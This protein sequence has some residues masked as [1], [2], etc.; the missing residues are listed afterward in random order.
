MLEKPN[1]ADELI[2]SRLQEEYGI[3]IEGLNFHPSGDFNNAAYS[4]IADDETKYFLKLRK[5]FEE[6][7]VTVPLFLRSQGIENIIVPYQTKSKH[8]WA[9]FG[10]YEII[11]YPFIEGKNGFEIELS[12][13]HKRNL[14]M[15]L[16]AIHSTQV[17]SKLEKDIP[18]ETFSAQWRERVKSF[19]VQADKISF[20]D[21]V[22]AKLAK[23]INSRQNEIYHL[24][25]HAERLASELQ[26]KSLELVLC[27]SDIH[28]RNI[29]ITE[30]DN[31]YIVDWDNPIL[32]PKERDLMFIGG[33]I[34]NIWT[35]KRNEAV[36]YEGYGKTEL[37]LSALAYYRFERVIQDVADYGTQLLLSEDGP[38]RERVY[39][40]FV[41]NF[42]PGSRLK[43]AEQTGKFN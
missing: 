38:D 31:L 35:S 12:D 36:F 15:A 42:E 32:A 41:T 3:H 21:P 30:N 8:Y 11:L 4:C 10:D 1:I 19:P 20:Q 27:H 25:A 16:K 40:Y 13:H 37:D 22:A 17:P 33:G 28:G 7:N 39:E 26:A 5:G 18:K 34:D 24:A 29:L 6:I 14:G 9:D 2:M 43:I 23:Y